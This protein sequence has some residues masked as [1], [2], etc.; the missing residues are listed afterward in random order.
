MCAEVLAVGVWGFAQV[1]PL[2]RA[3][4]VDHH[5]IS[6]GCQSQDAGGA[7]AGGDEIAGAFEPFGHFGRARDGV[8][9]QQNRTGFGQVNQKGQLSGGV[10]GGQKYL[11]AGANLGV[12]IQQAVGGIGPVHRLDIAEIAGAGHGTLGGSH[13]N[14]GARKACDMADMVDMAMGDD[15]QVNIGGRQ[16]APRKLGGGH[17]AH[18][19]FKHLAKACQAIGQGSRR[20]IISIFLGKWR[21]VI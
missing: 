4:T 7:A 17:V 9:G 14:R 21:V 3:M 15:Q 10:A 8:G 11:K 5:R 1:R 18:I 6:G 12:C 19:K 16:V 20:A 2:V 13:Q